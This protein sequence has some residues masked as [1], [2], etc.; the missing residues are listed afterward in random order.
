[1]KFHRAALWVIALTLLNIG[2]IAFHPESLKKD[3]SGYYI[4]HYDSCGPVALEQAFRA[5]GEKSASR[6]KISRSIQDGGNTIRHL[7][8]LV[9]HDTIL[10]STPKEMKDVCNKYGYQMVEIKE[11]DNLNPKKDVAIVLLFGNILKGESHWA[12]YPHAENIKNWFGP[13]TSISKV[14]LLKK[15]N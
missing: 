7:M 9:H 8:M 15:I 3:S 10:V 6:T 11:F 2:C 4:K 1:M 5:L 14:Y 13:N 12:S